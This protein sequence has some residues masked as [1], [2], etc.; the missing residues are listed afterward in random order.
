ML[1]FNQNVRRILKEERSLQSPPEEGKPTAYQ[2]TAHA[3]NTIVISPFN[4]ENGE[5]LVE[6]NFLAGYEVPDQLN[7]EVYTGGCPSTDPANAVKLD[8]GGAESALT[9]DGMEGRE[10]DRTLRFI[11]YLNSEESDVVENLCFHVFCRDDAII[12]CSVEIPASLQNLD[13]LKPEFALDGP[14]IENNIFST[15]NVEFGSGVTA[16]IEVSLCGGSSQ[17]V[18]GESTCLRFSHNAYPSYSINYFHGLQF[19]SEDGDIFEAIDVN[20]HPTSDLTYFENEPSFCVINGQTQECTMY[21]TLPFAPT[22]VTGRGQVVFIAGTLGQGTGSPPDFRT[23][24]RRGLAASTS[25]TREL[26]N[27]LE[28]THEHDVEFTFDIVEA[29]KSG[30]TAIC[31]SVVALLAAGFVALIAN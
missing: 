31:S 13:V 23:R 19:E 28:D 3:T 24:A 15:T 20:A 14:E 25:T 22:S 12:P 7:V 11:Q 9:Y 27:S 17:V 2:I 26:N 21:I 30:A 6:V 29:N 4:P 5:N 8:I 16:E 10:E 1:F 18:V